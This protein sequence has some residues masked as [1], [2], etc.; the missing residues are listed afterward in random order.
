MI[1]D[2]AF[3]GS[4]FAMALITAP[5]AIAPPTIFR[6]CLTIPLATLNGVFNILFA[7]ALMAMM[8]MISGVT[9]YEKEHKRIKH[10]S[11]FH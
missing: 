1:I 9:N 8:M 4:F 11:Y 3:L 10:G 7:A 5:L 2:I 6:L